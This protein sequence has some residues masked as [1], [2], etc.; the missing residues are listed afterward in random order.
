M[1]AYDLIQKLQD[2]IEAVLQEP[3]FVEQ[4]SAAPAAR[5]EIVIAEHFGRRR[6][7]ARVLS[8]AKSNEGRPCRYLLEWQPLTGGRAERKSFT[9]HRLDSQQPLTAG[10][11]AAPYSGKA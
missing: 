2:Q 6:V 9:V 1:A 4:F 10:A 11:G 8:V 7:A 5:K 3:V